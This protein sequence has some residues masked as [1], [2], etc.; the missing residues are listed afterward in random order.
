MI[1]GTTLRLIKEEQNVEVSGRSNSRI[2]ATEN[3]QG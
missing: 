1:L 3:I 2:E